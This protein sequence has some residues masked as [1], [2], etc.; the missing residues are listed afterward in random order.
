M[1]DHSFLP[2]ASSIESFYK[3]QLVSTAINSQWRKRKIFTTFFRTANVSDASG[4]NATKYYSPEDGGVYY[5]YAYYETGVLRGHLGPPE[6]LDQLNASA[7]DISGSDITKA[8]AGAARIGR[9]NFTEDMAHQALRDAIASNG[10]LSP[11][12]DGAGWRGTW[13][14]PVCDMGSHN[15]N[16]QFDNKSSRYGVLPCCCGEGCR[17]TREFVEAANL[18]GF[19]TLLYGCEEQLEGTDVDF[20]EVDYGF[21]KKKSLVFFWATLGTAKKAGLAIGIIVGGIVA[22]ILL[23]VCLGSC[24]C[25]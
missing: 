14:I 5:T 20:G 24:C 22:L 7:W 4:P 17:D 3:K 11:W 8:S 13:T 21:K 12:D 15:W 23:G 19:Q 6:G 2:S 1:V 18:G 16:T 10:S 25:R 9:F